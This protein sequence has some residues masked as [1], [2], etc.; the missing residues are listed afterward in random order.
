MNILNSLFGVALVLQAFAS[1]AVPGESIVRNTDGDY[2]VTYWNG[3][4][5][6]QT[7]YVPATKTDPKISS[8]FR[9]TEQDGVAYQYKLSNRANARQPIVAL[10]FWRVSSIKSSSPIADIPAGTRDIA[11]AADFVRARRAALRTPSGWS[12]DVTPAVPAGVIVE[13]KYIYRNPNQD[14]VL[15]GLLAGESQRGFGFV[16]VDLPGMAFAQI[17]GD[18]RHPEYEDDGPSADSEIANQLDKLDSEDFVPRNAA[19]P[20]IAL[21]APFDAAMLLD[22]IRTHVATWPGKQ[23]LDPAF[24]SQLDRYM[25]AAIDAYRLNNTK[26]GREHIETLRKMLAKEH[27]HVDHDDEDDDDGEERK[28]ATRFSIDRLAARV[29]DF[30]LRYVLKRMEHEHKESERKKGR[31]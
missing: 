5:L 15:E 28:H 30:D 21:P 3:I 6:M 1:H 8:G 2:I 26:A 11:A 7:K 19:V 10:Q 17:R 25:V 27:H 9:V 31:D 20:T 18:G 22:R 12:G 14:E 4:S 29:L 24:A 23:L 16:S 13:W